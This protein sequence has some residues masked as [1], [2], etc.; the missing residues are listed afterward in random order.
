MRADTGLYMAYE[1]GT[2]IGMPASEVLKLPIA[3]YT[4]GYLAFCN[5]KKELIEEHGTNHA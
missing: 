4:T 3:E 2:A 5:I 1:Y